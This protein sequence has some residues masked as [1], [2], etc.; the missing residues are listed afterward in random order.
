MYFFD[1]IVGVVEI[2]GDFGEKEKLS[3][4]DSGGFMKMVKGFFK[5]Q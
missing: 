5:K 2:G 4:G 3:G 1:F